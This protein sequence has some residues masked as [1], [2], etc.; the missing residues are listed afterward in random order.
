MVVRFDAWKEGKV[1]SSEHE[2]A[3]VAPKRTNLKL[4]A[5]SARLK[6]EL[7]HPNRGGTLHGLRFSPDGK[8]LIAGDYPGGVV[9]VWDV[10]SAQQ[11][12]TLE[13]GY[14]LRSSANTFFVS[15]DWTTVYGSHG[16]RKRELVEQ[17]GKRM[18]RWQFDGDVTAWDLP[19]GTVRRTYQ[20]QPPRGI[21]HMQLSADGN[22]FLTFEEVPGT[23]ALGPKQAIS[24]WHAGTGEHR[25]LAEDTQSFGL[26][27]P[28]GKRIALTD[29]SADGYARALKL[30]DAGAGRELWSV[31]VADKFAW[32]D[33]SAFSPDGRHILGAYSVFP[34]ANQYDNGD[35]WLKWY[36]ATDGRE[37]AAFA[38]G[39]NENVQ[40]CR[41]SPDGRTLAALFGR[42]SEKTRLSVFRAADQKLLKSIALGEGTKEERFVAMSPAFS[43]D[44][45]RLALITQRVPTRAADLDP[46]DVPQGRVLLIDVAAGEVRETIVLPQGFPRSLAFSPDGKLLATGGL[47][48]VLL[49]DV[50]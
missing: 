37:V 36:D 41:F 20:H 48:R 10:A 50:K 8:Q 17:D 45:S 22:R 25:T 38:V 9:V 19:A 33:V 12:T 4:E 35:S 29:T 42:R 39:K 32:L 28:D 18:S 47:G 5:V 21:L 1:S 34:K 6:Q 23:Y 16:R 49:W 13:T 27:S 26:F 14:G 15:P 3:V 43:P 44:G 40:R 7:I 2:V 11:L 31:P 24:V 46:R 30:F